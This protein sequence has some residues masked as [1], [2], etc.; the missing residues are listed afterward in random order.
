VSVNNTDRNSVNGEEL[1]WEKLNWLTAT[2]C[3]AGGCVQVTKVNEMILLRDSK[4]QPAGP[5]LVYTMDEW[6]AFL[7]GAK[8]GE[9]DHLLS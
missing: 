1:H 3:N 2:A 9:F 6:G 8:N 5:V 7:D 4:Q